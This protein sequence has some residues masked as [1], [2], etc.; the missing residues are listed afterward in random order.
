MKPFSAL[1]FS[2]LI[3]LLVEEATASGIDQKLVHLKEKFEEK[4]AS[5]LASP[6]TSDKKRV[7]TTI[8]IFFSPW[9]FFFSPSV[10]LIWMC[11]IYIY[12]RM[13][14]FSIRLDTEQTQVGNKTAVMLYCK[15]WMMLSNSER[16]GNCCLGSVTSA[17]RWLICKEEA[18][19]S[20]NQSGSL[21][22]VVAIFWSVPLSLSLTLTCL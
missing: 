3:L 17:A 11:Y 21:L 7:S 18:T 15:L 4:L 8:P 2:F 16:D 14:E 9:N 12:N 20:P 13:G 10:W 19:K 1:S 22:P 6:N 5:P